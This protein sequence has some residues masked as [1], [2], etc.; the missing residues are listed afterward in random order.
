MSVIIIIIIII[1]ILNHT[2]PAKNHAANS[3]DFYTG[4]NP[5]FFRPVAVSLWRSLGLLPPVS[6]SLSCPS[7]A[8]TGV[9]AV[10]PHT[11]QASGSSTRP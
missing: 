3:P 10:R 1:I 5:V 6:A 9:F 11:G 4:T 8:L 7:P 2:I